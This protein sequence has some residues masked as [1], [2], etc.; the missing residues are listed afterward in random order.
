MITAI[1]RI[2]DGRLYVS[3]E[4]DS[5]MLQQMVQ[6]QPGKP[7]SPMDLLS[8]RELE[9]FRLLGH[10]VSSR[11][12]AESLFLSIKTVD[13]YRANIKEKLKLKNS[14]QLLQHALQWVER[15]KTAKP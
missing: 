11:V 3:E 4:M 6:G 8:D 7:S 2:L 5:R 15:E 12:I 9:I 13:S 10:G 14:I 1:H